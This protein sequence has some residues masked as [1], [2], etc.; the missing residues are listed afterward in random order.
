[1]E[2]YAENK[3]QQGNW[4]KQRSTVEVNLLSRKNKDR[5]WP[6]WQRSKHSIKLSQVPANLGTDSADVSEYSTRAADSF[7]NDHIK[8]NSPYTHCRH[9]SQKFPPYHA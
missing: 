1:M 9:T 8:Q 4:K 7:G 6:F 5:Q 3:F 2:S